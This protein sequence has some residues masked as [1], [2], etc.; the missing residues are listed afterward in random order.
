MVDTERTTDNKQLLWY[1]LLTGELSNTSSAPKMLP[2]Q[3][4]QHIQ[5]QLESEFDSSLSVENLLLYEVL[6]SERFLD[7]VCP[8]EFP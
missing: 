5:L 3:E 7:F 1:K 4:T 2:E 8:V 6:L